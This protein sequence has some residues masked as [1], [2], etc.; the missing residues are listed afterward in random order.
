VELDPDTI[1]FFQG[2]NHAIN[3]FYE[4]QYRS[5][6]AFVLRNRGTLQDAEDCMQEAMIATYRN[7]RTHCLLSGA[8]LNA[9]FFGAFKK[10]WLKCLRDRKDNL[11]L[12]LDAY[13]QTLIRQ[14][15]AAEENELGAL[16]KKALSD[17]SQACHDMITGYYLQ[18]AQLKLIGEEQGLS[19]QGAKN[20]KAKCLKQLKS[21]FSEKLKLLAVDSNQTPN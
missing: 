14:S 4:S 6:V 20:K 3:K 18:G 17:L 15:P 13:E 8:P 9:Y 11:E 21:I 5:S 16:A 2:D 7:G 12:V 10:I 19:D 1:L